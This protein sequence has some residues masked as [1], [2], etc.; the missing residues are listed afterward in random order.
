MTNKGSNKGKLMTHD[1]LAD[2]DAA[3][4]APTETATAGAGRVTLGEALTI[5]D[6]AEMY[7]RLHEALDLGGEL[8]LDASQLEQVDAAG[9]QLLCALMK[10]AKRQEVQVSWSGVSDRLCDAARQ[11]G[12]ETE[13]ALEQPI[14]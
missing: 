2:L 8:Q 6:V 4:A 3:G 5:A 9:M 11:L 14:A 7:E 12:L 1:P 13:L 10:S